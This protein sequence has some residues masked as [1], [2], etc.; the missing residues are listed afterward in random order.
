M[1]LNFNKSKFVRSEFL[2]VAPISLFLLAPYSIVSVHA[3]EIL[4]KDSNLD[5]EIVAKGFESPTSMA[6]LNS[7]DIL[8]LEKGGK[9]LRVVDGKISNTVLTLDVN[10]HMER[11]LLGIAIPREVEGEDGDKERFPKYVF[12]FYTEARFAGNGNKNGSGICKQQNCEVNE[13]NNRLYRYEFKDNKLVNPKRLVDIPLYWNNRVYP[14]V[15]SEIIHGGSDWEH[16]PLLEGVH[17]GGALE[18]DYDN[19]LYLTTGDGGLCRTK[20]GCYRSLQNGFLNA[21]TANKQGGSKPTGIGGIIRVTVNGEPVH[22]KGVLGE[23]YPLNL[24]YAY[25][26]RNSFGIDFDP[27]TGKLWDTENGPYFGDEMNLVEPGFNSGWAKIQ[28]IWPVIN[29]THL[30]DNVTQKK[31]YPY[32]SNVP[33]YNDLEDFNGKGKYSEPEFT[34]NDS[35]GV[36]SIKFLDTDRLGKGYQNDVFVANSY[37]TIYHF[38]LNEDRTELDLNGPVNDK[39]ADN[40]LET[41]GLIFAQGLGTITDMEVGPDGYL[42]VLSYSVLPYT[43]TLYRILPINSK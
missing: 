18:M 39:V 29:Y 19:N 1:Y 37:G 25:G 31:G 3:A 10:Y 16:Y 9:V 32:S 15:H 5:V 40:D 30:M 36:T 17:Q 34:W 13:F 22:N 6:F 11:G 43:G 42:Y 20:D 2:L 12:L 26:I 33:V 21:Q 41:R 7:N 4:L 23:E 28:G 14:S 27:V 24:Y 8:V 35:I 38:D